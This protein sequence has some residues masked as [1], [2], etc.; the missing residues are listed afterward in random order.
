MPQT[1]LLAALKY[2]E[3]I[4][5]LLALSLV[6]YALGCDGRKAGDGV[7]LGVLCALLVSAKPQL[8]IL[9]AV[10]VVHVVW[11]ARVAAGATAL[12]LTASALVSIAILRTY[13]FY[14]HPLFP[15]AAVEG[16]PSEAARA[17]L[18]E[19]SYAGGFSPLSFLKT[20]LAVLTRQ[21]ETGF[22]FALLLALPLRRVRSGW[23]L[24]FGLVPF[25]GICAATAGVVNAL[26]WVQAPVLLLLLLAVANLSQVAGLR[27]WF[28]AL[29]AAIVLSSLGLA[30]VLTLRVMGPLDHLRVS[31]TAWMGR[32]I[33]TLELRS[34]LAQTEGRV[35]Y[36]GLLHGYYGSR[37]GVFPSVFDVPWCR[38]TFDA[39][40]GEE[41]RARLRS[42]GIRTIVFST[43][44]TEQSGVKAWFDGRI[45]ATLS[46]LPFAEHQPGI[47][48]CHLE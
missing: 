22:T 20:L 6:T 16:A 28:R 48:V 10:V 2:P 32:Y 26:R 43:R 21:P 19:N 12:V 33:P 40:D 29:G 5:T 24:S 36:V 7:V 1:L 41:L 4:T 9:A 45:A 17:L 38:S 39:A 27:R 13:H 14:G 18:Q 8:V 35:L 23:L 11:K 30:L 42:D 15:F 3:F 25:L 31:E 34:E 47:V 46:E 37:N 44:D